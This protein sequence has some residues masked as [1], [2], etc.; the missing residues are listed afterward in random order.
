[1]SGDLFAGIA[2]GSRL[3]LGDQAWLLHGFALA[4]AD[5][6]LPALKDVIQAAPF[7]HMCTP[8]GRAMSVAT[9]SCGTLGWVS[10][11][12]GYRYARHDPASGRDWPTM[13]APM[14]ELATAAAAAAGFPDFRPDACL[15]N[16][17]RP[18]T[19]LSLHQDRDEPDLG[20]PIVSVS[21]GL[22][23]TFLF[24][25]MARS[26]RAVRVPLDHGDVVV[27][28]GVDRLRFHGVLPVAPGVHPQLGAQRINLT[29][30]RAGPAGG[31]TA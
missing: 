21:L 20:Q 12:G 17:Y 1:M 29:F 5:A 4:A 11:R 23:A 25:G 6:L 10:D 14:R 7:R 16:R 8:G 3:Q 27:W 28:G 24:G 9:T 31:T 2:A 19:R 22:P 18:G 30:R 15:I 13:P 26:D